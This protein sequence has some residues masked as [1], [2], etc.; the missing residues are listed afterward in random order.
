MPD[1]PLPPAKSIS[2]AVRQA[3][4][5]D[6]G[7]GDVS[8]A[9]IPDDRQTSASIICRSAT[10]LCGVAWAGEVFRQVDERIR[11]DWRADDGD[12]LAAG[13]VIVRLSGPARGI[14]TAERT[15]LNF[16]QTLSGTATRARR[17]ADAVKGTGVVLLDTRKTLP[18]WRLAQKYAVRCGGCENHR[19]GLFDAFLIKENH[20]RAAG[21]IAAAI[22]LARGSRPDLPVEVEVQTLDELE[23]ALAEKP[24]RILLD[25]FDLSALKRAVKL[26]NGRM[27]LEASGGI[28][29]DT[30]RDV[31]ETGVDFIS[32]G[33]LTK[34]VESADL[35]LLFD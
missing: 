11:V 26:A 31:A 3:L 5:E 7:A 25:N 14:L 29:L 1:L 28:T 17:Y 27:P 35:S 30:I 4:A 16:L 20:I 15:A 32:L 23:T 13:S 8:A 33:A 24:D 34:D 19:L 9:L 21:G 10:V 12:T 2:E 22:G 18:G 6:I